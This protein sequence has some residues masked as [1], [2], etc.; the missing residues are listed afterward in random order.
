MSRSVEG[1]PYTTG[2]LVAFS[3]QQ[4]VGRHF[5]ATVRAAYENLSVFHRLTY[6]T[7][8]K[9]SRLTDS[10]A[11]PSVFNRVQGRETAEGNMK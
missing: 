8:P 5:I 7:P 6:L 10:N 2:A 3:A 1:C 4:R 11:C 9:T